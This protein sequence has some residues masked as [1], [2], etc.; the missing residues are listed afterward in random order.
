MDA[1]QKHPTWETHLAE[2][3]LHKKG[4]HPENEAVANAKD[5]GFKEFRSQYA[6]ARRVSQALRLRS[7]PDRRA[8]PTASLGGAGPALYR[9]TT[10]PIS[11]RT[12]RWPETK[13]PNEK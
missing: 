12:C 8:L 4:G 2:Q 9:P 13:K 5:G 11:A 6:R 10:K 3:L 1:G 7:A